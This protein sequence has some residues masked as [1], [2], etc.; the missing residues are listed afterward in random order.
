MSVTRNMYSLASMATFRT[1]L[2]HFIA[3]TRKGKKSKRRIWMQRPHLAGNRTRNRPHR[4]PRSIR[5]NSSSWNTFQY[6]LSYYHKV[7]LLSETSMFGKCHRDHCTNC[8]IQVYL[9]SRE[10]DHSCFY[11]LFQLGKLFSLYYERNN[12]SSCLR[13][14]LLKTVFKETMT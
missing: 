13:R 8:G 14:R 3:V 10:N 2:A 6:N 11:L 4:K 5:P 12:N 1:M 9:L 7:S